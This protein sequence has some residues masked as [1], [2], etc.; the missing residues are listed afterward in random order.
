M[1]TS[2]EAITDRPRTEREARGWTIAE[3]AGGRER[4]TD[5]PT[6]A[7]KLWTY[8]INCPSATRHFLL[9]NRYADPGVDGY[10][11]AIISIGWTLT[12]LEPLRR[13]TNGPQIAPRG[14]T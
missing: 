13:L 6:N 5:V 9:R 4:G 7:W 14:G 10:L 1:V 12:Y 3:F 2:T 11:G 8:W